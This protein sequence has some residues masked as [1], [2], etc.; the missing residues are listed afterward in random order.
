MVKASRKKNGKRSQKSQSKG[1]KPGKRSM[2]ARVPGGVADYVRLLAD[3]CGA[4]LTHAPYTGTDSGYLI[5][6][7]LNLK[8]TGSGTGSTTNVAYQWTPCLGPKTG[9]MYTHSTLDL[10]TISEQS[11]FITAGTVAKSRPVS[12]C[13]KWVPTG[14]VTSRQGVVGLSYTQGQIAGSGAVAP[15]PSSLLAQCNMVMSNGSVPHEARWLPTIADEVFS[16]PSSVSGTD[17]AGGTI[18]LVLQDVDATSGIP[19]GYLEITTVYE[20]TPAASNGAVPAVV[21]PTPYN[22]Q[23]V[24]AQIKDIGSL[25]FGDPS[26]AIRNMLGGMGSRLGQAMGTTMLTGATYMMG[27]RGAALSL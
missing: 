26:A 15:D 4:N 2:R 16:N 5:R 17:V 7:R 19:N 23:Q 24:L 1:R 3:P 27:R 22:T 14:P 13:L 12:S 20:W 18:L 25:L 9:L 6:T 11:D 8:P 21:R 10:W